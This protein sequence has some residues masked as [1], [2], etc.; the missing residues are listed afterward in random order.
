MKTTYRDKYIL[1]ESNHL[2]KNITEANKKKCLA[3]ANASVI[4][5]HNNS[6]QSL[7]FFPLL[8]LHIKKMYVETFLHTLVY[9]LKLYFSF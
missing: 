3:L 6:V 2:S 9:N 8:F 5:F 1:L 4:P 7:L